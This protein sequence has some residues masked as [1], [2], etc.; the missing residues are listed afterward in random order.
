MLCLQTTKHYPSGLFALLN[1]EFYF[2]APLFFFL[3]TNPVFRKVRFDDERRRPAG[4][5]DDD[6]WLSPRREQEY[7]QLVNS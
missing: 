4:I 1:F 3:P 2:I 6:N 7:Q 5:L